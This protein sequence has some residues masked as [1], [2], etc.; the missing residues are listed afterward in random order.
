MD[1]QRHLIE[2]ILDLLSLFQEKGLDLSQLPPDSQLLEQLP[3]P[4]LRAACKLLRFMDEMPGGFLIY[5]ASG[6]ERIVY[7]NQGLLH[8][9]Q[10]STFREFLDLTGGSFR[11]LVHPDDL[12]GVE[13]SIRQQIA[14][15]Q[16]DLDY[17]EYRITRKDGAIRW[18][19]DYGHFIH[20]E[21]GDFFYVFLDRKSTRLNSSHE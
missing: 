1:W 6:D 20:C 15:S 8:I 5:Y 13:D 14:A 3:S 4:G 17:V 11:G 19:E 7:A 18:I 9:F 21:A 10:C 12:D 2:H 16:Y